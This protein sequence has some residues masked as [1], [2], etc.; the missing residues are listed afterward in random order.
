MSGTM[1]FSAYASL[2]A[3]LAIG[4]ALLVAVRLAVKAM[5]GTPWAKLEFWATRVSFRS[6]SSP[7]PL[8]AKASEPAAEPIDMQSVE[9]KTSTIDLAPILLPIEKKGNRL[10]IAASEVFY[11][12][13]NAHYTYLFNGRDDLFCPLSISEIDARL[14]KRKFFRSHRSYIVNLAHVSGVR[15][16]ADAGFVELDS[17]Q[18]RTA[19]ISRNRVGAL[20][21]ELAVC[22]AETN[23]PPS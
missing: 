18:R 13:A 4:G 9:T 11:V 6:G 19:P 12:R 14:P 16:H 2:A 3:G 10:H 1:N 5:A 15:R 21:H 17:P 7:G 23:A 20:R 22:R 8:P